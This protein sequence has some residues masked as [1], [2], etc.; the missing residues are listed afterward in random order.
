MDT[1]GGYDELYRM[2]LVDTPVGP[3]ISIHY[4]TNLIFSRTVFR[5]VFDS[6]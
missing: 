6:S 1:T 4:L 2:L 3:F 5:G